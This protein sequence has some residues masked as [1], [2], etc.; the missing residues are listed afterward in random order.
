MAAIGS[1]ERM[2]IIIG[3]AMSI[4]PLLWGCAGKPGCSAGPTGSPAAPATAQAEPTPVRDAGP[5]VQC[6]F[7]GLK[8]RTGEAQGRMDWKGKTYYF[9]LQDHETACR[10]DPGSCFRP[11]GG[12]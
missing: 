5:L 12:P 11:D 10:K 9:D 6:P 2:K 7:C 1:A 4:F 3:F 8:L